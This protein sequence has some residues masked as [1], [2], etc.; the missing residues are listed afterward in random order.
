VATQ[1]KKRGDERY[2]KKGKEQ[3]RMGE[4]RGVTLGDRKGQKDGKQY[5]VKTTE[6]FQTREESSAM[7]SHN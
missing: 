1:K 4:K 7:V 2:H 6:P 3:G 5:A